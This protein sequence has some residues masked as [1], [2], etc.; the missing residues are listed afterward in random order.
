MYGVG[1]QVGISD[2]VFMARY[3]K[4]PVTNQHPEFPRD[5]AQ[6]DRKFIAGDAKVDCPRVGP[7]SLGPVSGLDRPH[8]SEGPGQ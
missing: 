4:Q 3:G 6:F 7:G 1:V 5:P 8:R 2:P